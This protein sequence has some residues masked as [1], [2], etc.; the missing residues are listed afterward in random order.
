MGVPFLS[1]SATNNVQNASP[2]DLST[3][4]IVVS[5]IELNAPKDAAS[6]KS[7][8]SQQI[9]IPNPLG[10]L[11]VNAGLADEQGTSSFWQLRFFCARALGLQ[12]SLH[13]C[14]HKGT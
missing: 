8:L 4:Q 9:E 6:H 13:K 7:F 1:T 11:A 10:T 3:N 2:G 5:F 14:S 12:A